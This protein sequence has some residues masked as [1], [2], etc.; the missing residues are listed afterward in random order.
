MRWEWDPLRAEP[1]GIERDRLRG[2]QGERPSDWDG[3]SQH[4]RDSR[5]SS[6]PRA[7]DD[8]LRRLISPRPDVFFGLP[9]KFY[10]IRGI[11]YRCEFVY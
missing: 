3:T 8:P 9:V 5:K 7:E 11:L 2:T 1:M 10:Q 6:R 4:A